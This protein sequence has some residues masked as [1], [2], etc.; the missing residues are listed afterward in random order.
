MISATRSGSVKPTGARNKIAFATVQIAVS[1]P[2]PIARDRT[3][4]QA[5]IGLRPRS[6]SPCRRSWPNSLVTLTYPIVYSIPFLSRTTQ[7]NEDVQLQQFLTATE[8]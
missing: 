7:Q 8:R 4:V 5:N 2:M 1:A 6:R 3:A